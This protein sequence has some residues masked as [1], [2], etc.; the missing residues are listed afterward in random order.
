M[1]MQRSAKQ[2]DNV[3]YLTKCQ[4]EI[5]RNLNSKP[6]LHRWFNMVHKSGNN[7]L[8]SPEVDIE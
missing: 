7:F 8:F 6:Q 2:Q 3:M 1:V 5:C 4:S